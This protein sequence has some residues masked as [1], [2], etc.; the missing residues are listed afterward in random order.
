VIRAASSKD[1]SFPGTLLTPYSLA[2]LPD[3]DRVVSTNS[4]MDWTNMFAGVSYQIWRLSDLKLLRTAYFDTD[5]NLYAHISPEE[6]RLG[7]DGAVYVQ[8]LGCGIERISDI[9]KSQPVS[10]LVHTFPGSGCGVP[11]IVGHFLIQSVPVMNGLIVL[12]IANGNTPKE[13]GRLKLAEHYESHWT[14]WDVKTQRIVVTGDQARLFLVKM[15]AATGSLAV[16]T[17][18]KLMRGST[19]TAEGFDLHPQEIARLEGPASAPA[20]AALSLSDL[21]S[22]LGPDAGGGGGIQEA[23]SLS[24]GGRIGGT[25]DPASAA[26]Q[27]PASFALS[28]LDQRP[29]ALQQV[30]PRYP[31]ELRRRKVQGTVEVVF[32]V[33]TD[34]RVM[35][36]K[37]DK[38]TNEAFNQPA[39]EAVRQWKFEA[40]TKEGKKVRFKMRVPITFS[41]G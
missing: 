25:G 16:D 32:L 12:D 4:S 38:T 14:A 27:G 6:P 20:L 28:E 5:K 11:T 30:L 7:P 8:T 19:L 31:S 33:D 41:A 2:V 29:Q 35:E 36:P 21:E 39:L 24:S 10:K 13:V 22:A 40:G 26:E 3:I 17:A 1:P 15:D 9:D 37:V 23:I 18:F 34:G